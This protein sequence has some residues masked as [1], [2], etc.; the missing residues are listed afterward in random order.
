MTRMKKKNII[1]T[2][3]TNDKFFDCC[4]FYRHYQSNNFRKKSKNLSVSMIYFKN[5]N[6][7][8]IIILISHVIRFV[9]QLNKRNPW[10]LVTNNYW[11]HHSTYN[12]ENMMLILIYKIKLHQCKLKYHSKYCTLRHTDCLSLGGCFSICLSFLDLS[13]KVIN[14]ANKIRRELINYHEDALTFKRT[15]K[16]PKEKKPTCHW[17][18]TPQ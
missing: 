6:S 11:W 4:F 5:L 2:S 3:E 9:G 18:I 10:K 15:S 13:G 7:L 12:Y 14:Q 1:Y 8:S 17:E 16:Y